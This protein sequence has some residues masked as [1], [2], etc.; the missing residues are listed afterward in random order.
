MKQTKY[1]F[2]RH[3]FAR[4]NDNFKYE[5]V[6]HEKGVWKAPHV[7]PISAMVWNAAIEV[8]GFLIPWCERGSI[9]YLLTHHPSE[10]TRPI[11][12]KW[13]AQLAHALIQLHTSQLS[14]GN[15]HPRTIFVDDQWDIHL[16]GFMLGLGYRSA[17]GGDPTNERLLAWDVLCLGKVMERM[18]GGGVDNIDQQGVE[19]GDTNDTCSQLVRR[20]SDVLING[21]AWDILEATASLHHCGC[22]HSAN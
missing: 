14:H 19:A 8:E 6:A 7:L 12:L 2:R 5:I 16:T 17:L 1:I 20:C 4:D 9:E 13:V 15:L 21:N 18:I 22:I 10:I 11:R 3:D